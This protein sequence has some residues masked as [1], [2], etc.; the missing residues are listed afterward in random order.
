LREEP[1]LLGRTQLLGE[2]LERVADILEDRQKPGY[3]RGRC[4]RTLKES[5]RHGA[6]TG[7]P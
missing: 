1:K 3:S 6:T 5:A 7:Q 4:P 2:A